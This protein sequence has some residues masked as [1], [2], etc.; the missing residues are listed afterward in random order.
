MSSHP[1]SSTFETKDTKK[2]ITQ[3]VIRK[4]CYSV[5][6]PAKKN[7]GAGHLLTLSF[8][9]AAYFLPLR[10]ST[11]DCRKYFVFSPKRKA[12]FNTASE[13]IYRFKIQSKMGET[14]R[15]STLF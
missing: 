12:F 10:T 11:T 2:S 13:K 3:F 9:F 8:D 5:V 7:Q 1:A 4:E 14:K 15:G 6:C